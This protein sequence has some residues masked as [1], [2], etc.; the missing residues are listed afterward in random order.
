MKKTLKILFPLLVIVGVLF[1]ML[2]PVSADDTPVY[3]GDYYSIF[4]DNSPFSFVGSDEYFVKDQTS[5]RSIGDCSGVSCLFFP[6]EGF[7]LASS[8][9]FQVYLS[10]TSSMPC[11][12]GVLRQDT[13]GDIW[14][15]PCFSYDPISGVLY[16]V[17]VSGTCT[18]SSTVTLTFQVRDN[19]LDYSWIP[20]SVN[21]SN[22]T[23]GSKELFGSGSDPFD[24]RPCI[25]F[26][27]D[28]SSE[29][30]QFLD[31]SYYSVSSLNIGQ[32]LYLS[33]RSFSS[34]YSSGYPSGYDVG[35]NDGYSDARDFF[36]DARY[37]AGLAD[38]EAL[39][40]NDYANGQA[41]GEALHANDYA[42]GQ[43]RGEA[44]HAADFEN[45]YNSGVASG[46]NVITDTVDGVFDGLLSTLGVLNGFSIFGITLGGIISVVAILLI[47]FFAL[48][49][50]RK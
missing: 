42:N 15:Y 44:L 46:T 33:P 24:L 43:A 22:F 25:V 1:A 14:F 19:M 29:V 9:K 12:I 20:F 26:S 37:S 11:T 7:S 49:V 36:Y 50:I 5:I 48:K 32:L 16:G 13:A 30:F 27:P 34:G 39:H 8:N 10:F 28:S 6:G 21:A 31:F 2:V 18:F 41:Y 4:S 17:A 47:V 23:R 45:G 35:F 38:G 40:A 3:N